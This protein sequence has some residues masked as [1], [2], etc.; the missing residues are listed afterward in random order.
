MK[1]VK[2]THSHMVELVE[3]PEPQIK[4][5]SDV[6]I[7]VHYAGICTNDIM[8]WDNKLHLPYD[9]DGIGHEFSGEIVD[10]G[11][12]AR[13]FGLC[14]GDRVSGL[15]WQFC[16]KC[17]Y[18]RS[19][20]ENMCINMSSFVGAMAEYIVVKDRMV[21]KLPD[22]VSMEDGCMTE[23]VAIALHG[24]QRVG[25]KPGDSVLIIGGGISGQIM[26]QL[27][28]MRGASSIT[29][30]EQVRSKCLLAM[31]Q[32]ADFTIDPLKD[33]LV[34]A[35]DEITG[36]LGYD[37]IINI[38]RNPE[39]VSLLSGLM[40]KG[41]RVLLFRQYTLNETATLNLSE[42]YVKECSIYTAYLAPYIL[43]TTVK[44]L[45]KLRLSS[46]VGKIMPFENVQEAFET[47]SSGRYPRILMKIAK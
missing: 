18:C 4:E 12:S 7:R 31:K 24:I 20:R 30:C 2:R 45:P 11:D 26:V 19:G 9:N 36:S 35:T 42:L 44:I 15:S 38:S 32:G 13:E 8:V 14:V 41:G 16:G 22:E 40:A 34:E 43:D 37:V 29:V 28:K 17:P 1:Q 33:N 47:Y 46:L 3:V 39:T 23:A 25:I 6:K 10:L 27:A 21:C 5:P